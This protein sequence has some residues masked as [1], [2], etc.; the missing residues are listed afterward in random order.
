MAGPDITRCSYD[1][2][3]TVE[4]EWTG[5]LEAPPTYNVTVFDSGD[6]LQSGPGFGYSG[7]VTLDRPLDPGNLQYTVAAAPGQSGKAYG[8]ALSVV[9][10]RLTDL[11]ATLRGAE[12]LEVS[13]TQPTPATAVAGSRAARGCCR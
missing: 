2:E 4:A 6:P 3:L 5:I 12:Q 10:A 9:A 11:G 1:G 7:K 8:A 13:W